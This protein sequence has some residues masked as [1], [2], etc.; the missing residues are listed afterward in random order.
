MNLHE[1]RM[2]A[3]LRQLNFS[4]RAI[5]EV[6]YPHSD[7]LHGNQLAGLDLCSEAAELLGNLE[8]YQND[9]EKWDRCQ[10]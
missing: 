4:W 5:A 7:D 9:F 6:Y 10:V 1:A 8:H 3:Q 2:I